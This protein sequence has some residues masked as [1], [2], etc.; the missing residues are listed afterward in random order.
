M[1]ELRN[2]KTA[3]DINSTLP[4]Q[5]VSTLDLGRNDTFEKMLMSLPFIHNQQSPKA[6]KKNENIHLVD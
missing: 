2:L 5:E 6:L 4:A 3:S 1:R